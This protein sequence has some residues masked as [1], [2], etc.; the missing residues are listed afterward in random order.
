MEIILLRHGKPKVE[1]S[2]YLSAK[3][4]KQLI[5]DYA[6]SS[7]NDAPTEKLK[8]R[9]NNHYVV[10]SDLLRSID[11]AKKLNLNN[12]NISDA[13]YRETYIPH[14]D[15]FF[16]KLPATLWLIILRILWLFGFSK[17]GESF[18]QAKARSKQAAENLIILARKNKKVIV[19]GHGLMNHLIGKELEKKDWQ[20]SERIGKRYWEYRSYTISSNKLKPE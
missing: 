18:S 19:V 16:L 7:I 13:L 15:R 17:N 6:Q 9:F 14:F 1:L 3:Q 2:G 11:S 10:C 12:I 4:L 20:P 8:T 5:S